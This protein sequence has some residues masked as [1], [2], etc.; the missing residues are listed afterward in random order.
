MAELN[1][2]GII[3]KR[4]EKRREKIEKYI[5]DYTGETEITIGDVFNASF[6]YIWH[7]I[8]YIV[9]IYTLIFWYIVFTSKINDGSPLHIQLFML[10]GILTTIASGIIVIGAILVTIDNIAKFKIIGK[11]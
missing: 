1:L 8:L 11:K 7:N 4:W 10:S 6:D 9:S 5:C 2:F 3:S